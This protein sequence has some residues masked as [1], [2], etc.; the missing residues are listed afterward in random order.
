MVAS[1]LRPCV[2]ADR[3]HLSTLHDTGVDEDDFAR[4]GFAEAEALLDEPTC[5]QPTSQL[6]CL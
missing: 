4:Q 5:Q 6:C 2:S 1:D 3:E